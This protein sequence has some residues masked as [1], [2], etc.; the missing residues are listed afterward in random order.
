MPDQSNLGGLNGN[1]DDVNYLFH[2][3]ITVPRISRAPHP[4]GKVPKEW[5]HFLECH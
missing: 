4:F 1:L 3:M 5:L 2:A